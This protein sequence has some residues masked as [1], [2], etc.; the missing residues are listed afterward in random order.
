MATNCK[1]SPSEISKALN[2]YELT[3]KPH[4]ERL[5]KKVHAANKS[6][7]AQVAVG[8]VETDEQLRARAARGSD[9]TWLHE[10]DV[11]RA[12]EDTARNYTCCQMTSSEP[13][14]HLND[15]VNIDIESPQNIIRCVQAELLHT[16]QDDGNQ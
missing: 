16:K 11:V 1:P 4:A 5:L 10:H 3:R 15:D 9:T 12:F 6:K 7:A 2:L 14:I 13:K 8:I